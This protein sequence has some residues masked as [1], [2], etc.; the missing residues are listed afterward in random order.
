MLKGNTWPGR[1]RGRSL[2][3]IAGRGAF[4][5][6]PL[7]AI[8]SPESQDLHS[9]GAPRPRPSLTARSHGALRES[10]GRQSQRSSVQSV[11][12]PAHVKL[13]VALAIVELHSEPVPLSDRVWAV[14]ADEP[15]ALVAHEEAPAGLLRPGICFNPPAPDLTTRARS[16]CDA[17]RHDYRRRVP[18]PRGAGC[19]ARLRRNVIGCACGDPPS[20]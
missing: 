18:D 13:A 15:A 9:G 7:E 14:P 20:S 19:D 16:R 3:L 4:A 5:R 12:G 8:V 1:T 2:S 11:P 10:R 6:C 17:E